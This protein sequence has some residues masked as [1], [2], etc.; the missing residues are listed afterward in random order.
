[1]ALEEHHLVDFFRPHLR[2]TIRR[3]TVSPFGGQRY[4]HADLA[5]H[6]GEEVMVAI[7]IMDGAR[8]WVKTLDGALLCEA[9][10]VEATGYR[11]QSFYEYTMEKRAGAQIKR[12][13]DQIA[14][15]EERMA[16]ALDAPAAA[17]DLPMQLYGAD[18]E[19]PKP[20]EAELI[21]LRPAAQATPAGGLVT[22]GSHDITDLAM[23]LYGDVVDEQE[24]D[25]AA[26]GIG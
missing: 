5:H 11:A 18:W 20:R 14:A 3:G 9:G 7:D 15:I 6:E 4:Y 25:R 22:P 10:L 21:P 26:G 13:A 23:Y 16:P 1:M 24:K 12:K 8:V 2:K 19:V 17:S